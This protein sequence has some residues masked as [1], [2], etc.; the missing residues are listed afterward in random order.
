[1]LSSFPYKLFFIG[2]APD[3]IDA[4]QLLRTY[5]ILKFV[6]FLRL[7]RVAKIKKLLFKFEDLIVSNTIY[8]WL[9]FIK[10]LVVIVF[11]AH[12]IACIFYAIGIS[13]FERQPNNWIVAAGI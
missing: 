13:E 8:A 12:W 10:V 1:M 5:K 6:R 9:S 4:P 11:I 3:S 7:L 2:D